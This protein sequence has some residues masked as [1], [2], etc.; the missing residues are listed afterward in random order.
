MQCVRDE[1]IIYILNTSGWYCMTVCVLSVFTCWGVKLRRTW[2]ANGD[3]G[4]CLEGKV[5]E[6][7]RRWSNPTLLGRWD[8][9]EKKRGF[10]FKAGFKVWT[11]WWRGPFPWREAGA[12]WRGWTGLFIDFRSMLL[13]CTCTN[14]LAALFVGALQWFSIVKTQPS[15]TGCSEIFFFFY[16]SSPRIY[17]IYHDILKHLR[18]VI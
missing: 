18:N 6:S 14:G 13:A 4:G 2:R 1:A 5:C 9:G 12:E 7:L 3:G 11:A 8:E 17:K 15:V 16:I 10:L